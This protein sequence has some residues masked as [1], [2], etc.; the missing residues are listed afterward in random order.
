MKNESELSVELKTE[1][2]APLITLSS[3]PI[4]H[5]PPPL[6]LV[7]SASPPCL[8]RPECTLESFSQGQRQSVVFYMC[9]FVCR[10][11]GLSTLLAYQQVSLG[12]LCSWRPG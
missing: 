2:V 1:N 11:T 4:L 9:V 10:G 8:S 6:L 5:H 7:S 3:L 12:E